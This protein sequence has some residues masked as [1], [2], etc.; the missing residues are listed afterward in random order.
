MAVGGA[1]AEMGV[2]EVGVV[3]GLHPPPLHL[4]TLTYVCTHTYVCMS[5]CMCVFI[6][7]IR[8]YVCIYIFVHVFSCIRLGGTRASIGFSK[9]RV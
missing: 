1:V 7:V 2:V 6:Y 5:A 9:H 8:I 3:E 4:Y